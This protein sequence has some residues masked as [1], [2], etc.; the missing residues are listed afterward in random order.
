MNW[1]EL[2][3]SSHYQTA[4]AVNHALREG[5]IDEAMVGIEE[6]I[7]ALT[8]SDKRALKSHLVRLMVHVIKWHT[9]PLRRSRSW[10]GTINSARREIRAIQEDTPSLTRA[11]IEAQWDDCFETAKEE[12]EIQMNQEP[13][14]T[15]ISWAQAFEEPYELESLPKPTRRRKR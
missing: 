1:Q 12:A 9:Q 14:L 11:V 7:E 15:S 3:A 4:V 2:A 6:L 5:R 10:R 13:E 8:R